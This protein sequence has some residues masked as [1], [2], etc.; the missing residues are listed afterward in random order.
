MNNLGTYNGDNISHDGVVYF[1][2]K[3][4]EYKVR[5]LVND[6]HP[7]ETK[8]P[9]GGVVYFDWK[10]NEYKV[11]FLKDKQYRKN[12]YKHELYILTLLVMILLCIWL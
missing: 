7:I 1:D 6:F 11:R 12:S 5:F 8:T 3:D 9:N 2:W 10:D 4:N